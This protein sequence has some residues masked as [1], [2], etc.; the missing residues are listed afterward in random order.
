ML[1]IIIFA[2]LYGLVPFLLLLFTRGWTKNKLILPF[3]LVVFI[4]SLYE[5]VGSIIFRI[6]VEYWF[7]IYGLISFITI[8]YYFYN[9]LNKKFKIFTIIS[10]IVFFI[11]YIS[12]VLM[13]SSSDLLIVSSSFKVY[14]TT[15]ILIFSIL[16]FRKIFHEFE[17]DNLLD[18]PAFY[19]ISGLLIYYCGSVV[20]FLLANDLYA[21][22]QNSFK[23]YWLI[24]IILTFVLRTLLIVGIWK[25]RRV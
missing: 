3:T 17:I 8:H 7:L 22:N 24:N 11:F 23:Y 16:W 6:N 10:A 19:F 25:A 1:Y 13:S 21:T 4:A 20:L 2:V 15:I 12:A 5:F 18:S 9:L 14:Q